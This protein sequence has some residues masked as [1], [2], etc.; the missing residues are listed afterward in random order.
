ML[1]RHE[2]AFEDLVMAKESKRSAQKVEEMM[3]HVCR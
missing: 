3:G 1:V 2:S